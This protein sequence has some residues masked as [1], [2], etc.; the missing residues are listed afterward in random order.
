MVKKAKR[1]QP[2]DKIKKLEDD[3]KK[4]E[5]HNLF[6]SVRELEGIPNK[7]LTV[8]VKNQKKDNIT[9]TEQVLKIRKKHFEQRLNT[10]FPHDGN[11]LQSI[12]NITPGIEP[13]TA[14]LFITEEVRKAIFSLK[15]NKVTESDLIITEVLKAGGEPIVNTLLYS[16]L[17]IPGKA[18]YKILM[19]K[20]Y[21][22][23]IF[24]VRQLI[25]K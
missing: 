11:I 5:F 4:N 24:F 6:T 9:K 18:L 25:Q 12:L 14:E 21:L 15:N 1:K 10:E 3:F 2:H 23:A 19:R 17:S 20:C 22:D 8:V 7:S 16:P 13:S